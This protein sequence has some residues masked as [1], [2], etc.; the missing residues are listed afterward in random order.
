MNEN[1][2]NH[3]RTQVVMAKETNYGEIPSSVYQVIIAEEVSMKPSADSIEYNPMLPTAT[4]IL[5]G[6]KVNGKYDITIKPHYIPKGVDELGNFIEPDVFVLLQACGMVKY[7]RLTI[8]LE[9]VTGT[10][11]PGELLQTVSELEIGKVYGIDVIDNKLRLSCRKHNTATYSDGNAITGVKSGAVGYIASATGGDTL[12]AIITF[13]PT[14][15]GDDTISGISFGVDA[16]P[17]NYELTVTDNTPDAETWQVIAPDST[18]LADATSGVSYN[19][20]HISFQINLDGSTDWSIGDK[21]TVKAT[22]GPDVNDFGKVFFP[23]SAWDTHDSLTILSNEDGEAKRAAGCRGTVTVSTEKTSNV[24]FNFEFK[25]MMLEL[26]F[27]QPL[28]F[29]D[30][31]ATQ[32]PLDCESAQFKLGTLGDLLPNLLDTT[33]F[34]AEFK[35]GHS[36]EPIPAMNGG[37]TAFLIKTDKRDTTVS[38]SLVKKR[39]EEWD[40]WP[41]WKNGTFLPFTLQIGNEIGKMIRFDVP[42]GQISDDPDDSGD[43]AGVKTVSMTLAAKGTSTTTFDSEMVISFF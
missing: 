27:S 17:G 5:S 15:T 22:Y 42:Y 13:E 31:D 43:E 14:N 29:A 18:Q 32:Q 41:Y 35:L 38:L 23:S 30:F 34:K 24:V 6:K 2:V 10:F 39:I 21:I 3:H 37:I 20:S 12:S 28:I 25:G 9:N 26:P 4:Q 40:V 11:L 7:D 16:I 36:V 33:I 8:T 1:F 19:T